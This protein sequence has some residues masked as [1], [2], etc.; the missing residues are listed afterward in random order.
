MLLCCCPLLPLLAS[1]LPLLLCCLLLLCVLAAL[2]LLW[3]LLLLLCCWL[4]LLG[5]RP[6][7]TVL[8]LGPPLG[9]EVQGGG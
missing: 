5:H 8:P 6:K 2:P 1:G 4:P 7:D 9:K 3:L